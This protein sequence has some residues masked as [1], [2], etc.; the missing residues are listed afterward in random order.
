M[1]RL[2]LFIRQAWVE[3]VGQSWGSQAPRS[4]KSLKIIL[5]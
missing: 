4:G 3:E 1:E 2:G 5:L